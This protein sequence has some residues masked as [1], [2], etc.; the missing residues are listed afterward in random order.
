MRRL[1]DIANVL[2]SL[3]LIEKTHVSDSRK[4]AFRWLGS[5]K[6]LSQ[7]GAGPLNNVHWFVDRCVTERA[8][9]RF[10]FHVLEDTCGSSTRAS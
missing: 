4:P 8:R 7:E 3:H 6:L 2:S 10:A 9:S 1:Y 5:E